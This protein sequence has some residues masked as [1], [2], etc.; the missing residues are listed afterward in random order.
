S[1]G[2]VSESNEGDNEYTKTIT[3]S[4]T[5]QPNL[6]PYQPTGWSDKIVVSKTTGTSTDSTGLTTA[7]SL[8]VDWAV[9]NLGTSATASRFYVELYVDESLKT[10]WYLD[11]PMNANTYTP[12]QDYFLGSL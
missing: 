10:N 3:V 6:L 7:D 8:Y 12:L 1:Q 2:S 11:P 4:G 5:G 9:A